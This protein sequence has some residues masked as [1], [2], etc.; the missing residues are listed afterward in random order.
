M[1]SLWVYVGLAKVHCG[2][3]PPSVMVLFCI[4]IWRR[5]QITGIIQN[6]F[7]WARRWSRRRHGGRPT[8]LWLDQSPVRQ[9]VTAVKTE[10]Y[11]DEH[12]GGRVEVQLRTGNHGE[13]VAT[14]LLVEESPCLLSQLARGQFICGWRDDA[15]QWEAAPKPLDNLFFRCFIFHI[16]C[17]VGIWHFTFTVS[18]SLVRGATR[19][20]DKESFTLVWRH[21]VRLGVSSGMNCICQKSICCISNLSLFAFVF[22]LYFQPES[23][24]IC[25]LFNSTCLLDTASLLWE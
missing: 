25:V 22:L 24:C 10:F 4:K 23:F 1:C 6:H 2:A 17:C 12:K 19:N 13:G 18:G 20:C 15:G 3:T 5:I 7:T 14:R 8:S 11:L 21:R 16:V 9:N